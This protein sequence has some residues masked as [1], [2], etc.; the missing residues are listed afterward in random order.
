MASAHFFSLGTPQKRTSLSCLLFSKPE[1]PDVPTAYCK[2]GNSQL[3]VEMEL[4]G[5]SITA[6]TS[7]GNNFSLGVLGSEA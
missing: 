4:F 5:Y 2:E 7:Q 6:R 3:K 1:H